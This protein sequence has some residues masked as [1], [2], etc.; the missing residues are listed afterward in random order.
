MG[1]HTLS[2]I[3]VI[4]M[5][6]GM[7]MLTA[8]SNAP[9]TVESPTSGTIP[10]TLTPTEITPV[11]VTPTA[12]TISD[13]ELE[14]LIEQRMQ[15]IRQQPSP[16]PH[17]CSLAAIE[18]ADELQLVYTRYLAADPRYNTIT[19]LARDV[20][21]RQ[22]LPIT[23]A[24][25]VEFI[26][27]PTRYSSFRDYLLREGLA[28]RDADIAAG[29]QA[30]QDWDLVPSVDESL[31]EYNQRRA[32]DP[33]TPARSHIFADDGSMTLLAVGYAISSYNSLYRDAATNVTINGINAFRFQYLT[34]PLIFWILEELVE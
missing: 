20:L 17:P 10:P 1:F 34:T 5:F 19:P 30:L 21:H 31:Y 16:T 2:P 13:S 32:S 24:Y 26:A 33:C 7:L 4:A 8:C 25:V 18:P 14:R 9:P 11:V 27:N 28:A 22:F 23:A 15:E 6:A 12:T 3:A 29:F